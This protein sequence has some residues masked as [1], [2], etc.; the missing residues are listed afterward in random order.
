MEA[1]MKVGL[2]LTMNNPYEMTYL[3]NQ[4][5]DQISPDRHRGSTTVHLSRDLTAHG[6]TD[7]DLHER[8]DHHKL[9]DDHD[10]TVDDLITELLKIRRMTTDLSAYDTAHNQCNLCKINTMNM[11][12]LIGVSKYEETVFQD[13]GKRPTFDVLIPILEKMKK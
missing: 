5:W 3:K 8:G 13:P 12:M 10:G 4:T 9:D 2:S 6:K 11:I 7:Q 1:G